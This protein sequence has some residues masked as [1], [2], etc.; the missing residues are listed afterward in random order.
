MIRSNTVRGDNY[1]AF[2]DG[3]AEAGQIPHQRPSGPAAQSQFLHNLDLW[4]E[5]FS[6]AGAVLGLAGLF[7]RYVPVL[8]PLGAAAI[9]ILSTPGVAAPLLASGTYLSARHLPD[10]LQATQRILEGDYREKSSNIIGD[11]LFISGYGIGILGLGVGWGSFGLGARTFLKSRQ[12]FLSGNFPAPRAAE[13]AWIHADAVRRAFQDPEI[14]IHWGRSL[15]GLSPFQRTLAVQAGLWSNRLLVGGSAVVGMG[16]LGLGAVQLL[17]GSGSPNPVGWEAWLGLLYGF[18]LD[19]GPGVTTLLYRFARGDR[20]FNLGPALSQELTEAHYRN[21]HLRELV[22]SRIRD[23]VPSLRP[24]EEYS[25]MKACERDLDFVRKSLE[26]ARILPTL[27]DSIRVPLPKA[28]PTDFSDLRAPDRSTPVQFAPTARGAIS[29][30]ILGNLSQSDLAYWGKVYRSGAVS[31]LAVLHHI[32]RHPALRNSAIFPR[33][34]RSG[35]LARLLRQRALESENR[36]AQGRARPLEG[37]FIAVKDLF[38]GLDG[39][40]N[41]GSKTARIKSVEG[42]PVLKALE[43]LG[44]IPFPVGMVAAAN[45]G[46]GMNAGFGYI[47]HPNRHKFDPAGSSSAT[48]H[49]LGLK[50]FPTVVGIGTDTGGS[51][52]AP[53]GAVGLTSLVPSEILLSTRNMIPFDTLLD[54]VGFLTRHR[55]D[56]LQLLHLLSPRANR[57]GHPVDLDAVF[58]RPVTSH[59]PTVVYLND[60]LQAASKRSRA[61]FQKTMEAYRR[62]GFQVKALSSEWNFLAEAPLLLYP[63]DAYGAAAFTHTNP[64]QKNFLEPPR[65]TLDRNLWT[66]LP[67]GEITLRYGLFDQARELTQ[68]YRRLVQEKLGP[69]TV[70]VSPSTEAISTRRLLK[71]LAGGH[72]DQHDRIT[73]AK[74]RNP[75][76]GQVNLPETPTAPVGVAISGP[77]AGLMHFL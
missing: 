62:R 17:D 72:L 39:L 77:M 58:R 61:N 28:L 57:N 13:N 20:N 24:D 16:R 50:D 59:R 71:G 64:L 47:P 12:D 51:V 43:D 35:P 70:L 37:V 73:M 6:Q 21:P 75:H 63:I 45:G 26:Q 19:V 9:G 11:A 30:E 38:P 31:P 41:L 15:Q 10:A 23:S 7:F 32:Q 29:P 55:Q 74:N 40:M 56:A 34:I 48:A 54:R 69:L 46:S 8:R 3:R 44:A 36:M 14:W 52:T 25:F 5:R 67:K 33:N 60:V 2:A 1:T 22:Y 4:T 76:W 53:A 68:V 42:N 66:R 49:I 18:A 27:D 65:R